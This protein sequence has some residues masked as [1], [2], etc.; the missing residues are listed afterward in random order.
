MSEKVV[1]ALLCGSTPI[2]L[3]ALNIDNFFPDNIIKLRNK[4]D[5]DMKLITRICNN[6]GEYRKN[7]NVE[8]VKDKIN[9]IKQ[10]P[11]ILS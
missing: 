7:I 8:L 9:I 2:Y 5:T 6:P 4:I 1:N 11:Y 10:F 3:G